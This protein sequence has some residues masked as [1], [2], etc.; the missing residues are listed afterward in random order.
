MLYPWEIVCVCAHVHVR[1]C[2]CVCQTEN[3]REKEG[4]G[5]ETK[6]MTEHVFPEEKM[7]RFASE[8]PAAHRREEK[9]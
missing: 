3:Y 7:W 4:L 5:Q 6:T 8:I 2:V 1:V 9:C